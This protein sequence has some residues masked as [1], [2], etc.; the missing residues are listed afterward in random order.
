MLVNMRFTAF[1]IANPL[2]RETQETTYCYA[3]LFPTKKTDMANELELKRRGCRCR[4]P[5][6]TGEKRDR[7]IPHDTDAERMA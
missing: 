5:T 2:G 3:R 1:D 7:Q 4:V 6:T